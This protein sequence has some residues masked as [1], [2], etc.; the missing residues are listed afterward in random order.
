MGIAICTFLAETSR[1]FPRDVSV[2]DSTERSQLPHGRLKTM[3][4][5]TIGDGWSDEVCPNFEVSQMDLG[6]NSA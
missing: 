4:V 2:K 6:L 1:I 3:F 5:F